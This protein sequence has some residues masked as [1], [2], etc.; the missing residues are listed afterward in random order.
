MA[1]ECIFCR[2]NRGQVRSDIL[3]RDERCFVIKDIA[4]KA[5]VHLLI[6]P[7]EHFTSLADLTLDFAPVLGSMFMAAS[8][9]AERQGIGGTGYR[10]IINQGRDAGQQVAHLHMHLLG[11]RALRDM[12]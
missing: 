10:L 9:M 7:V 6:I 8:A 2:I 4:P 12:G 5:P 11:G 3:Y 1:Q